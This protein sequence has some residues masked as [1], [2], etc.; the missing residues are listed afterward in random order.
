MPPAPSELT[1]SP[2]PPAGRIGGWWPSFRRSFCQTSLY[3]RSVLIPFRS[4]TMLSVMN[5]LPFATRKRLW[6]SAAHFSVAIVWCSQPTHRYSHEDTG[7][8]QTKRRLTTMQEDCGCL[9]SYR[10]SAGRARATAA[11][12]RLVGRPSIG[13]RPSPI[14]V[15]D[16][17]EEAAIRRARLRFSRRPSALLLKHP[18]S[19]S[20]AQLP[21][22]PIE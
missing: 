7:F 4:C 10:M 5:F 1:R 9:S 16:R 3:S 21:R 19:A 20:R 13:V 12:H 2:P 11:S 22:D 18:P 14:W 6:L 8:R 15:D 17:P